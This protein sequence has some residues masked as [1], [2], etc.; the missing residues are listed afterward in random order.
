MEPVT[1]AILVMAQMMPE[2]KLIEMVE[3]AI[4]NYKKA[5]FIKASVESCKSLQ[6]DMLFYMALLGIRN[7]G[8]VNDPFKQVEDIERVQRVYEMLNPGKS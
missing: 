3:K 1:K 8:D 6:D 7:L 2:D 5:C 4:V